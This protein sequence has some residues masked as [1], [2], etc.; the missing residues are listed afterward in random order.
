M[1]IACNTQC[2]NLRHAA[3]TLTL[4]AESA[5]CHTNQKQKFSQWRT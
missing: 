4:T 2:G 1:V 5:K 3:I